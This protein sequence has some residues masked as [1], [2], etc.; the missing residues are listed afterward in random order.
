MW[1]I[2]ILFCLITLLYSHLESAIEKYTG[3]IFFTWIRFKYYKGQIKKSMN[4]KRRFAA[5][6]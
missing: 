5:A 3:Y 2:D 4:D 6:P 1:F